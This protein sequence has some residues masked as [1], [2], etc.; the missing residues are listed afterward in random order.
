MHEG[1]RI[2][3]D[4]P[5]RGTYVKSTRLKPSSGLPVA[6][7][8]A[9]ADDGRN[10]GPGEEAKAVSTWMGESIQYAY[11]QLCASICHARKWSICWAFNTRLCGFPTQYH[12]QQLFIQYQCLSNNHRQPTLQNTYWFNYTEIKKSSSAREEN[13][14]CC[15]RSQRPSKLSYFYSSSTPCQVSSRKPRGWSLPSGRQAGTT[16]WKAPARD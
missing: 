10:H 1:R 3:A 13:L 14:W 9:D 8:S 5:L 4:R 2:G 6:A 15:V 12:Y 11:L 7:S 16:I